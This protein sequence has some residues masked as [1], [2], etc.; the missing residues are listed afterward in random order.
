MPDDQI[1]DDKTR[2]EIPVEYEKP[3]SPW[4][5]WLKKNK[6][7][8]AAGIAVILIGGIF[9]YFLS[10]QTS[11][12]MQSN[13]V[14]LLI[15]G[16]S[17]ITANNEAEYT[18][19]YRNG[20]N[21]G[22]VGLT[23]E[24][25]YPSGWTFKSATPIVTNA[26]GTSF[27]LP[28]VPAGADGTVVVRGK[29]SGSTGEDKEIKARLQYKLS[30]FNSSFVVEQSIHTNILPPDLTM[31][32]SGPVD[33]IN[34]QD[35]TFTVT[36]T[37]VTGQDFDNLGLELTYP[38]G[39]VFSAGSL[40]PARSNNYWKLPKLASNSSGSV[41]ITGSFTGDANS[42]LLL[43][44]SLGQ[45]INGNFAPQ[46]SSTATFRIIPSSLAISIIS[47]HQDFIKTGDS[48]N[49]DLQY[50]NRGS[51]GLNNLVVTVQLDSPMIDY[52]RINAADAIVTNHTLTWKAATNPSLSILSPN[53]QGKI[54]FTVPVKSTFTSNLKNQ[55]LVVSAS[56]SSDETGKATKAS[57]LALKLISSLDLQVSG[58]YI[59]GPV[60]MQVGQPT[61][62]VVTFLL[63]N[64]SNDS[65]QTTVVA[66]LPLPS[67]AWK[68]V[69]VPD[70]EKDRLSYDP[71][72]G[73]I[74][75][76]LGTVAAFTGR[77]SPAAKATFQLQV[78]PTEADRGKTVTLLSDIS[79]S[80]TDTFVNQPIQSQLIQSLDSANMNDDTLN[81]KGTTVQ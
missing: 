61:L 56:I 11:P 31:D 43:A 13:N 6:L 7:W 66:S 8:I 39:F 23:L 65:S 30:N 50:A 77:F 62:F 58:D 60:P 3:E 34:G 18:I 24:V 78:T 36:Y 44:A 54:R 32:I 46:I 22:L 9:W 69:V 70:S 27:N 33:V 10:S 76:T 49:F 80:G 72:S 14:L 20:E 16:P 5:L 4:M 51:I 40:S 74:R 75:W 73:K 15:K 67:S 71:N 1:L 19:T 29:L 41:E 38:A 57:P 28:P 47:D 79:A 48:I 25:F 64:Y 45:I 35:A 37:N 17:Q 21:A 52:A 81:V 42:Q 55:S 53:E 59:S 2:S 26:N 68:N 63:S 12:A